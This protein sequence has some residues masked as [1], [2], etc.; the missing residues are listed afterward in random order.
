MPDTTMTPADITDGTDACV[1][2]NGWTAHLYRSALGWTIDLLRPSAA[3]P[4]LVLTRQRFDQIAVFSALT[5]AASVGLLDESDRRNALTAL[6]ALRKA[7]S[8]R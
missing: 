2:V 3:G 4:R 5:H 7:I 8:T 6:S 1:E